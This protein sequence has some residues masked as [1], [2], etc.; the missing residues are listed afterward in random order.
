MTVRLVYK[1]QVTASFL[2]IN[3]E[4]NPGD[5]FTVP[6]DLAES[7]LQRSDVEAAADHSM[8]EPEDLVSEPTPEPVA[9]SKKAAQSEPAT[10]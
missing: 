1:G 3:T 10:N 5:V 2:G 4:L 7:F 6:D 9:K 8:A